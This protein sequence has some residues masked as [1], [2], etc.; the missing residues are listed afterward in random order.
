MR[1]S[2]DLPP[3]VSSRSHAAAIHSDF[4]CAFITGAST[5][6]A[7]SGLPQRRT[8]AT[9]KMRGAAAVRCESRLT[10][11]TRC[12]MVTLRHVCLC[13][14][15]NAGARDLPQRCLAFSAGSILHT[16]PRRSNAL[17]AATWREC[18]ALAGTW[19]IE[20]GNAMQSPR[21]V[22]TI[23]SEPMTLLLGVC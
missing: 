15:A 21:S 17:G 3:V 14:R 19:C 12:H 9:R 22:W 7:L 11:S 10:A 8:V 20:G 2:P 5:K 18:T 6:R 1:S 16:V 23:Q 13:Q 4:P